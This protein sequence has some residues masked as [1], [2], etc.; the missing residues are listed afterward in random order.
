MY[1]DLQCLMCNLIRSMLFDTG[2]GFVIQ[3]SEARVLNVTELYD[4]A[5]K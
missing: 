4:K 1:N 5:K 3:K 2:N